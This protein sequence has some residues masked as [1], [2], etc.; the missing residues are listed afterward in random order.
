MTFQ[1]V[2][3]G[4]F[5][6]WI[7]VFDVIVAGHKAD[8]VCVENLG[9]YL[10]HLCLQGISHDLV[11]VHNTAMFLQNHKIRF[12]SFRLIGRAAFFDELSPA[13]ADETQMFT[14]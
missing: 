5:L 2:V 11:T 7:K 3:F 1:A 12:S 6:N 4:V 13:N 10:Y 14:Q 8:T 9:V